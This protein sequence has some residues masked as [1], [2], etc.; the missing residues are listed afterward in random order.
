MTILEYRSAAKINLTL[1]ILGRRDDGY[2]FLQS[3]VHTLDWWDELR[4]EARDDGAISLSCSRHELE[5]DGNLCVRAARLFQETLRA[6][7]EAKRATAP[8]FH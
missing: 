2:H 8:R 1:D 3:L 7:G 4:F 5:N 6:R